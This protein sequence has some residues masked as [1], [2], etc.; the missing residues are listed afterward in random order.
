M[1]FEDED[2]DL[3]YEI[4][5]NDIRE[6]V[7]FATDWTI[8]SLTE[9]MKV[10]DIDFA[11]RFQR[12][13]VWPLDRKS[14]YIESLMLHLPVPSIVLAEKKRGS[15]I[16]LDGKQRLLTIAQFLGLAPSSPSNRFKLK[17]LEVLQD[18]NNKDWEMVCS[19]GDLKRELESCTIRSI[20]VRNWKHHKILHLLFER[21]NTEST[22]L[23]AQEL[24]M[25]MF[26]G[27]FVD[28]VYDTS[29]TSKGLDHIFSRKGEPHPRMSDVEY[30]L[31]YFAFRNCLPAY[32]GPIRPF[33]DQACSVLNENWALMEPQINRQCAEFERAVETGKTIFGDDLGRNRATTGRNLN[34]AVLDVQLYFLSQVDDAVSLK[35]VF[36]HAWELSEFV[37]SIQLTPKHSKNSVKRFEILHTL[38]FDEG[39]RLKAD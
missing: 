34:R 15:Y 22:K 6:T 31:R 13:D 4:T 17:K 1:Q 8:G 25:A 39:I 38:L 10:G 24:R 27:P 33:L 2:E 19:D 11:P 37:Q 7:L 21:L 29:V 36:D 12:R 14:R 28:F 3:G 20:V 18:L 26:P 5:P 9:F 23:V 35:R 32:T 30:L 16:V